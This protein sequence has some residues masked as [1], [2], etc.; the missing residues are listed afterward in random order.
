MNNFLR[1][2][3]GKSNKLCF[4]IPARFYSLASSTIPDEYPE[5]Q[6]S[7][8]ERNQSTYLILKPQSEE[9]SEL[10]FTYITYN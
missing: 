10:K 3:S 9:S 8:T 5:N 6:L 4:Q 1:Y 7:G 2:Y